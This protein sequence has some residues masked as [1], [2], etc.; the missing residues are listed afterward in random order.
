MRKLVAMLL[1]AA[2]AAS[3]CTSGK[4]PAGPTPPP[5]GTFVGALAGSAL[6]VAVVTDGRT[7][8]GY[9]CD[10]SSGTRW[11]GEAPV[12]GPTITL[13]AKDGTVIVSLGA[14]GDALSGEVTV[15]GRPFRLRAVRATGDA[16][17]FVATQTVG[18]RRIEA[19]WVSLGPAVQAGRVTG[20]R[21]AGVEYARP[22]PFLDT[23]S[24]S[25]MLT[26]VPGGPIRLTAQR[27][28]DPG[29]RR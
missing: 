7:A 11:L 29:F 15:G 17:L 1:M 9:V 3:G 8:S 12:T 14:A 6:L 13:G 10:G 28:T 2:L 19:G 22:A 18:D 5:G 26:D 24:L 20:F 4:P 21:G 25:V 23:R 16:G 27:V